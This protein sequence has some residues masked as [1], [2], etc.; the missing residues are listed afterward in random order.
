MNAINTAY[1]LGLVA[2]YFIM[3]GEFTFWVFMTSVLIA[4]IPLTTSNLLFATPIVVLI[5]CFFFTS[6]TVYDSDFAWLCILYAP[7]HY[8]SFISH[9]IDAIEGIFD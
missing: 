6:S 7:F 3:G 1:T 2:M 5:W 8:T 9:V 4:L